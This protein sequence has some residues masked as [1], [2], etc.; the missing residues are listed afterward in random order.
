MLI[1]LAV[2]VV[3]GVLIGFVALCVAWTVHVVGQ[4][5]RDR[6]ISLLST[7]DGLLEDRSRSLRKLDAELK[8]VRAE[9]EQSKSE[10]RVEPSA[11]RETGQPDP[12]AFLRTVERISGT[13][14]R[15]GA[16][17]ELYRWVRANFDRAPEE[18]LAELPDDADSRGGPA[19]E[20][21]AKLDYDSV[22][23]LSTLP[24]NEQLEVLSQVLSE[25]ET[26]LLED[27]NSAH[28]HF[29]CIA[30]YDYLQSRA[31]EEP[32]AV[33]LRVSPTA[34]RKEY[35]ERVRVIVDED[36]CE[37]FQVETSNLLYDYSIKMK[38][39]GE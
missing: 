22:Y 14:Y 33:C 20:L 24:E 1:Y 8:R 37:G 10:E 29:D 19:G 25:E 17:G 13:E 9:L 4:N 32:K 39:M 18:V 38:E 27:Y 35:P 15:D 30:F 3:I 23:Q 28:S 12:V 2:A 11:V 5:I 31:A 7:Y 26:V 16:A 6:S 21:L 34:A 36:I